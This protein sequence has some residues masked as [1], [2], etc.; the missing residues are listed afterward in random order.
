MKALKTGKIPGPDGLSAEHFKLMPEELLTYIVQIVNLIFKDKD[1]PQ[2]T[3]EGVVSPVH[4]SGKDK[5]HPENYR[6]ITV[7]NTF[8]TLIEGILKDRLE[9]KLL[10][11]QSKLQ[12][13]F[14]EKNIVI[15]YRLYCICSSMTFTRRS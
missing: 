1:L 13:G 15:E 4:K 10:K 8:S 14:T 12:R 6:G 3:K 2:E 9:P 11:V 5:L 7:T